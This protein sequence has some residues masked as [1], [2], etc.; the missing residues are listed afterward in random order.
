[1]ATTQQILEPL[2]FCCGNEDIMPCP[3][4]I[5]SG[6]VVVCGERRGA[7]REGV[8]PT[9]IHLDDPTTAVLTSFTTLLEICGRGVVPVGRRRGRVAEL[10]GS[11]CGTYTCDGSDASCSIG[12]APRKRRWLGLLG[13]WGGWEH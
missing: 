9:I 6:Y 11:A 4:L 8:N 5:S 2:T 3:C 1:M 12:A 13:R 10:A 7:S